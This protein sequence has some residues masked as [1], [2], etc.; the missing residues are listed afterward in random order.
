MLAPCTGWAP[1]WDLQKKREEVFL[2]HINIF[3]DPSLVSTLS[4][5]S[6]SPPVPTP[7][8]QAGGCFCTT[9][10]VLPLTPLLAPEPLCVTDESGLSPK[11]VLPSVL[12]QQTPASEGEKPRVALTHPPF[13]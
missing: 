12:D 7:L 13:W 8:S 3:R 6:S 11:P 10:A 9:T 4:E 5:P 2:E 1:S